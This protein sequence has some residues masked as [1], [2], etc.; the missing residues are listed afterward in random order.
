MESSDGAI[1]SCAV[2]AE[3]THDW[4]MTR[5]DDLHSFV[6]QITIV[7][8]A[9]SERM[10]YL[11][12][13][14][15]KE[16]CSDTIKPGYCVEFYARPD[17]FVHA[18][19]MCRSRNKT[20]A[21]IP[22]E[23]HQK[24]LMATL[25]KIPGFYKAYI[26]LFIPEATLMWVSNYPSIPVTFW[27]HTAPSGTE[28][29]IYVRN[30][31]QTLDTWE[32]VPCTE[33][34]PFV[35]SSPVPIQ[36]ASAMPFNQQACPEP[37]IHIGSSCFFIK[38]DHLTAF[39]RSEATKLCAQLQPNGR[40]A[41]IHSIREQDGLSVLL[42][43]MTSIPAWIGLH[44]DN[45]GYKWQNGVE[46]N[47]TNW[48][49][50]YPKSGTNRC[51]RMSTSLQDAGQWTD[52]VCSSHAGYICETDP[53]AVTQTSKTDKI[54]QQLNRGSC[55]PGY[56]QFEGR[57]YGLS[58]QN[59]IR[60]RSSK[61]LHDDVSAS[62]LTSM[63]FTGFNCTSRANSWGTSSCP[64]AATPHTTVDA[65][66]M[67]LLLNVFGTGSTSAWIGLKLR[68]NSSTHTLLS[69]DE[70]V[71]GASNLVAYESLPT[72]FHA[73]QPDVSLNCLI[74]TALDTRLRFTPCETK[75]L[76][77]L[78]SYDPAK[79]IN[80]IQPTVP[81]MT[82]CPTGWILVN[83]LCYLP[84]PIGIRSTWME[85]EQACQDA[86]RQ[87]PVGPGLI[88]T[89]HLASLH[90]VEQQNRLSAH[91]R[92]TSTW[93][94]LRML[95]IH[96][97]NSIHFSW[98]DTSPV[99]YLGFSVE[100][101]RV[102]QPQSSCLTVDD[103]G[104]SWTPVE[105]L[106]RRSYICQL[107]AVR[108]S[109]ST[110]TALV[111][112]KN[113]PSC[114]TEQFPLSVRS[115]NACYHVAP[116]VGS[117]VAAE[118]YCRS[119]NPE[120]HLASIHSETQMLEI[121]KLLFEGLPVDSE[122]WFG[123]HENEFAYAWSDLTPVNFVS[124]SA[125]LSKENRHLSEDCFILKRDSNPVASPSYLWVAVDCSSR[126]SGVLCQLSPVPQVQSPSMNDD[127]T[128]WNF[129]PCPQ[130]YRQFANRC[131]S[132]T[133]QL[134]SWN[135]A[136]QF[137]AKTVSSLGFSGSLV[138]IDSGLVQEFVA[139][140]LG[141]LPLGSTSA[142]IGLTRVVS[143]VAP[144]LQWADRSTV[145]YLRSVYR[146]H[147]VSTFGNRISMDNEDGLELC[148]VLYRSSYPRVNGL[149]LQLRCDLPVLLP[150]VCQAVPSAQTQ[151]GTY[152][153]PTQFCPP[154]F[155]I[156]TTGTVSSSA[157]SKPMCYRLLDPW[158]KMN[159]Q[160]AMIGCRKL[161]TKD[162]NVSALSI[163]SVFEA[164]FLRA[165]L[166]LPRSLGGAELTS[167][168]PV[169]SGLRVT[170]QCP[171]CLYNWTWNSSE[172]VRYTDWFIPPTPS[173]G[174]CYV[175]HSNPYYRDDL[176]SINGLGSL[177]PESTCDAVHYAV[178]QTVAITTSTSSQPSTMR[179]PELFSRFSGS[180]RL[181]SRPACFSLDETNSKSEMYRSDVVRSVSNKSCI[182]WDLVPANLS[183]YHMTSDWIRHR[184][185]AA[186][187]VGSDGTPSYAENYCSLVFNTTTKRTVFG[188]Y[189]G[190]KP[191]Q[192]EHC[193]LQTCDNAIASSTHWVVWV[194]LILLCIGVCVLGVSLWRGCTPLR[195]G[196][197]RHFTP[198]LRSTRFSH[199][200]AVRFMASDESSSTGPNGVNAHTSPGIGIPLSKGSDKGQ[201][202]LLHTDSE[203]GG[204]S[205]GDQ[206]H[207]I[208]Q[209]AKI[210]KLGGY[211]AAYHNPIY[212]TLPEI[213]PEDEYDPEA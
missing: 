62:C 93:F 28:Q 102:V 204:H 36:T 105:C 152:R 153:R 123:L 55:V 150:S 25:Q 73:T 80:R 157:L 67:R 205:L 128:G 74:A 180:C 53:I 107:T 124:L 112:T 84:A 203:P 140:L 87:I 136:N 50:G 193:Q 188:C 207:G 66:F 168:E 199:G 171:Q 202:K 5:C 133:P 24:F 117:W 83:G 91:L 139:S 182:R 31:N 64:V 134:M 126:R 121:E 10:Q 79:Q 191:I 213:A 26:G 208:V 98:S 103:S 77:T 183:N 8:P 145:R 19:E 61:F 9:G 54:I 114:S 209:F 59:E 14:A 68:S 147:E 186:T 159:W 16:V 32:A 106:Q 30:D 92:A 97:D 130:G 60:T 176:M 12:I 63:H 160:D 196:Y 20:L 75:G 78:C 198:S 170:H 41:S 90:S 88:Y 4:R 22:S 71:V 192:F 116:Y 148:S 86:T 34:L 29:C 173:P 142:W 110:R 156:G 7:L 163:A 138:T 120:A 146:S 181:P 143:A 122:I 113:T 3:H 119:L 109:D 155:Y 56:Y 210:A 94:G 161:T 44:S 167:T 100:Q 187:A 108:Q 177:R 151:N 85:A 23:E 95:A 169:W 118:D 17:T 162:Y 46:V 201:S 65:A 197:R 70:S 149:W 154:G 47:F 178:C 15:P 195:L 13:A 82:T 212:T 135:D 101:L 99:D 129:V 27:T 51:V 190:L 89:G 115:S 131:F 48:A 137:C 132:V 111:S 175:F 33:S 38:A 127:P 69:E 158:R 45:H 194:F 165:W 42:A 96:P 164:S 184:I 211:P 58:N 104:A 35:C 39:N 206:D 72:V 172:P 2:L 6:C 21:T 125:D 37:Y 174:G 76:P 189:V 43:S 144:K 40:L 200:G 185:S 1:E 141:D 166:H 52:S 179:T 57:C 81:S 49:P 18:E 11:P